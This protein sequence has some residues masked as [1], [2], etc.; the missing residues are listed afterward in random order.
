MEKKNKSLRVAMIGIT[1]ALY[2]VLGYLFQPISFMGLQFRVAELMVGICVLYPYP[3]VVGNVLGV[4]LLNLSSPLGMMDWI[5]GP[6]FNIP[7]SLF[8]VALRERKHLKYVG[9]IL[10]AFI[11]ASYVAFELS[12]LLGLPFWLMFLQ[13]FIAEVIL[14]STGIFLFSKINIVL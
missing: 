3:G 7:A 5:L 9:G 4:F 6:L 8:I 2:V 14:A 1:T 12:F 10:Y 13:V 11:I